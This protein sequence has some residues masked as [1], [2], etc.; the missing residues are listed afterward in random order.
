METR[1]SPERWNQLARASFDRYVNSRMVENN[2]IVTDDGID[3]RDLCNFAKQI[4]CDPGTLRAAVANACSRITK[5]HL[6]LPISQEE[7]KI[8]MKTVLKQHLREISTSLLNL[9]REFGKVVQELNHKN[10]CLHTNVDELKAFI[11]PL[12]LEVMAEFYFL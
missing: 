2:F 4:D 9:K 6:W 7:E 3:D 11:A 8:V 1:M 5:E 12:H 10:V